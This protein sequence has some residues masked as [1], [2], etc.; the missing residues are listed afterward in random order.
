MNGRTYRIGGIVFNI[1]FPPQLQLKRE[2]AF[3]DFED[4][5]THGIDLICGLVEKDFVEDGYILYRENTTVILK[6]TV[7]CL[8]IL[9]CLKRT[10]KCSGE[11]VRR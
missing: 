6:K 4:K 3:I 5:S 7:G 1:L 8:D 10:G 2:A 11:V 9:E